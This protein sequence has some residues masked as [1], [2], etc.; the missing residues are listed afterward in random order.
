MK[1]KVEI[2]MDYEESWVLIRDEDDNIIDKVTLRES[3]ILEWLERRGMLDEFIIYLL[4][5][6]FAGNWLERYETGKT[7]WEIVVDVG[8]DSSE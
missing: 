3:D 2:R 8:G 1:V 6:V 4:N 7:D 5:E